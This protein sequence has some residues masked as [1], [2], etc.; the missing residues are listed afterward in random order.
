MNSQFKSSDKKTVLYFADLD[1]IVTDLDIKNFLGEY[2]KDAAHI[3]IKGIRSSPFF[4]AIIIFKEHSIAQK[5]KDELNMKKLRNRTC[6]I[7]W[8]DKEA[9]KNLSYH[10]ENNN[11]FIKNIPLEVSPREVFEKFAK[12]GEIASVKLNE[13]LDGTHKGYGYIAY[14]D[15]KS[16]INALS[17]LNNKAIFEKYPEHIIEIEFFKRANERSGFTNTYNNN[18]YLKNDNSSKILETNSSLF[19]K[20]ISPEVQE[21]DLKKLFE[22]HGQITYFKPNI[23]IVKSNNQ[24][25]SVIKSV[26]ISYDNEPSA[27]KAESELNNFNL[28]NV[29]LQVEKLS[30]ENKAIKPINLNKNIPISTQ[31]NKNTCLFIKNIPDKANEIILT[32]VFSE[33]GTIKNVV[34]TKSNIMQK[35]NGEFKNCE[36]HNGT[37]QIYFDTPEEAFLAKD[38]MNNKYL[39]GFE[40]WKNPLF[41]DIYQSSKERQANELYNNPN[42]YYFN[43]SMNMNNYNYMNP[44]MGNINQ[45]RGNNFPPMN[46]N[47]NWGGQMNNM[48]MNQMNRQMMYP[49]Y[50][51]YNNNMNYNQNQMNQ[52][53]PKMQKINEITNNM[54]KM[55]I[56]LNENTDTDCPKN[57]SKIDKAHLNN[58]PDESQKKE[59][60]GEVIFNNINSHP[61]LEKENISIDE[62]GKITGMILGIDDINEIIIPCT[63]YSELTSRIEEA[64]KL[65]RIDGQSNN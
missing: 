7:M 8:H 56:N 16:A 1:P 20:N 38:R 12:Y 22:E 6:R 52:Q 40:T 51:N 14:E 61:L 17:D 58:L 46:M 23:N 62:V 30:Y 50:N 24:E 64:L 54:N 42:S 13:N 53:P 37:G 4:S 65:I 3:E 63:S 36:V 33:F 32:K 43:P 26:I 28:K 48:N 9:I 39:P 2:Q 19:V 11:I 59:Y 47:M 49:P 5:V 34:I 45:M 27:A 29:R 10:T 15:S 35:V 18:Y 57:F 21:D 44:Y 55:N 41:V 60:M 31:F 25:T